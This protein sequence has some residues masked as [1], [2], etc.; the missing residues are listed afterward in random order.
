MNPIR[1]TRLSLCCGEYTIY[2]ERDSYYCSLCGFT[3][4]GEDTY[5]TE[6][7]ELTHIRVKKGVWRPITWEKKEFKFK[8]EG[9]K[10]GRLIEKI[11]E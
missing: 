10:L 5:P 4:E 9:S 3:L 6:Y 8:K 7:T 1:Y 11:K 2:I